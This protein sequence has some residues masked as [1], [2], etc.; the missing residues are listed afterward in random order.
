MIKSPEINNSFKSIWQQ[1]EDRYKSE[2]DIKIQ[3]LFSKEPDRK[4]YFTIE[5]DGLYVDFSKSLCSKDT[6][7]LLLSL[8][9]TSDLSQAIKSLYSGQI[10]N[11]SENRPALHVA[12]RDSYNENIKING[13]K[14][15]TLVEHELQRME[16]FVNE[17]H[18]K[19]LHGFTGKPIDTFI[20]IGIGGSDLGPRLAVT[21]LNKYHVS[22]IR[23]YF[24]ANVDPK[25]INNILDKINPETSLFCISSK[26]FTTNETLSNAKAARQWLISNGCNEINKHM[27]AVTANKQGA[28]EFGIAADNCFEIWPWVGGR[29]SLWSSIGMPIAV[30]IGMK[31]FRRLLAG[32]K[33]MDDHF[34]TSHL[35]RNIPVLL[36]LLDIWYINFYDTKTLAVIPYDNSLYLLPDYLGQLFMESNGKNINHNGQDIGYATSPVVWGST[37]TNAQ[38][39]FF[40]LLHQGTQI[41]PVEFLVALKNEGDEQHMK[42][43]ANCIAQGRALMY[44]NTEDIEDTTPY[45]KI[46]GNKPSTTIVIDELNPSTLGS[47][48]AMY[49]HRAFVQGHLWNINSFD[50]WGVE[51]GKKLANSILEK[52]TGE[53]KNCVYDASTKALISRFVNRKK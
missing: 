47:L 46:A 12:L 34:Y 45:R 17:L 32:A 14:I 3:E 10:V 1:L 13:K 19:T 29:F 31:N 4:N 38:H 7:G 41:V 51:L 36:A 15:K 33:A 44:G 42:L 53:T 39:A 23:V 28:E 6:L 5:F 16:Q 35:N 40:Q 49:E 37:G 8:A 24:V 20:N 26:S 11:T 52:L 43:F 18:N 9:D 50:Q 2:R 22:D 48:L 25:D 27:F 21:A 30:S